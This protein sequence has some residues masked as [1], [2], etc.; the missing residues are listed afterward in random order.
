MARNQIKANSG[1]LRQCKIDMAVEPARKYS[2]RFL[3][4]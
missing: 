3:D 4:F 2:V 1:R